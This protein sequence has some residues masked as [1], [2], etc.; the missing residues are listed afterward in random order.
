[1]VIV[2]EGGV[3]GFTCVSTPGTTVEW[4]VNGTLLKEPYPSGVRSELAGRVGGSLIF[5]N[6]PLEYDGTIVQCKATINGFITNTN[7][8]TLLVQGT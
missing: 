4:L 7:N 3:E 6:V 1:M 2:F 8:G 5:E